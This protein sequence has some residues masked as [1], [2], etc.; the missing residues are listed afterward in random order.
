MATILGDGDYPLGCISVVLLDELLDYPEG[1]CRLGGRT[2][3]GDDDR[4]HVPLTGK[5][6]QFGKVLLGKVVPCEHHFRSVPLA[7]KLLREIMGKGLDGTAG[8]Q[9][10]S[11]DTDHYHK[12]HAL[13]LPVVAD[14][15]A[16]LHKRLGG[17]AGKVLP[18]EEVIAFT[19]L[20]G[21]YVES[22]ERLLEIDLVL[23]I[24]YKGAAASQINFYHIFFSVF[25]L[26]NPFPP[27]GV[28][29]SGSRFRPTHGSH[30]CRY[31]S[32]TLRLPRQGRA[33][34]NLPGVCKNSHFPA[35]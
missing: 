29:G 20:I 32:A 19:S 26:S 31:G 28:L 8:S 15:F 17:L 21:Q 27:D 2:G 35:N 23:C 4:S 11:S 16:S 3:L 10:G 9:V 7:G 1:D 30:P 6:H 34:L 25:K 22:G 14:C 5:V 24:F 12:V 18:S 33:S 13:A